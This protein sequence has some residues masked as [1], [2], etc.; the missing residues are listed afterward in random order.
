M[1]VLRCR[2]SGHCHYR[3]QPST[4]RR[5][6]ARVARVAHTLSFMYAPIRH[7]QMGWKGVSFGLLVPLC[8][9]AAPLRARA[10]DG[11]QSPLGAAAYGR[12]A[13]EKTLDSKPG[14]SIACWGCQV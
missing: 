2:D 14:R 5:L 13:A 10:P 8:G 4:L 3:W 6:N 11:P 9:I 1:A 7:P 12:R